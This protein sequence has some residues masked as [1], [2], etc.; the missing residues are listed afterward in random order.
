M[1]RLIVKLK[2]WLS[3]EPA[4]VMR[5]RIRSQIEQEAADAIASG[6]YFDGRRLG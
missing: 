2:W 6:W 4:S 3:G 5:N 1:K